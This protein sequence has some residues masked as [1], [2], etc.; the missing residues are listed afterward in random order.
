VNIYF[1]IIDG[2]SQYQGASAIACSQ[3]KKKEGERQRKRVDT[4]LAKI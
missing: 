3:K 2:G 1:T 4:N